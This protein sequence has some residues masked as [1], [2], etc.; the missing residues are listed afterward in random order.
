M[1]E[2]RNTMWAYIITAALVLITL[3]YASADVYYMYMAVYI[4][5]GV[6]YGMMLQY[7][8]FCFASASRDLFAA[9]VPRMAVGILVALMFFSVIQAILETINM[10]T[11]HAAPFGIHMLIA[12]MVFGVGMVFSGGCASGSLYK[13]GEGN[14]TS[15]LAVIFGLCLGQA[16]FVD[17]G[18]V[19]LNLVPQGWMDKAAQY[20]AY[21]FP[22]TSWFDHYL[23]GYVWHKPQY[24]IAKLMSGGDPTGIH[25]FIGNAIVNSIIPALLIMV[26][27]ILSEVCHLLLHSSFS[28]PV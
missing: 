4:W 28:K 5:F 24:T 14:M 6:A 7:G 19:F 16:I 10:S 12:G 26:Q 17:V 20:K 2:K 23:V 11:F 9:G 25:F 1:D 13:V 8:R 18:G 15:L 27:E 22:V 3:I 21:G